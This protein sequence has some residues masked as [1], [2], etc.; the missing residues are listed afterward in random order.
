MPKKPAKK[1]SKPQSK[2]KS[3]PK[4]K[5]SVAVVKAK[6]KKPKEKEIGRVIH[7]YD[8]ISVAVVRLAGGLKVGDRVRVKKG[9]HEFEHTIDSM[10]LDHEPIQSGKKGQEVALK[11]TTVT[12][13]GA[14]IFLLK[15]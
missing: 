1:V 15:G 3:K 4:A 13:T 2:T 7:W 10:Q 14:W 9:D 6:T 8:R 12:K 5:R 11:L